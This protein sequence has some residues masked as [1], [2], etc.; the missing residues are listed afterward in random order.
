MMN[1]QNDQRA[2]I[3]NFHLYMRGSNIH[4]PTIHMY[5]FQVLVLLHKVRIS[6][7]SLNDMT[8]VIYRNIAGD[9]PRGGV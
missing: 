6:L 2:P 1:V 4:F 3:Y 7:L 9:Q 8:C 5:T